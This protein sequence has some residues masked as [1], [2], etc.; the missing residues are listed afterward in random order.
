MNNKPNNINELEDKQE[1]LSTKLSTGKEV[2]PSESLATIEPQE[3]CLKNEQEKRKRGRPR[4]LILA[5]TQT[6]V[7]E[8]SKVGT[9]HEDIAV[10]LGFSEDT[11]TKYYRKE[12]DKGRI[13]ANAAVAGTLYEK[14]KQ[15]DTA[16]M[17]FWLKTRAGWSEKNTTELTGEGGA[18]INIKVV[19]GID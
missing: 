16:S 10:L 9:R 1:E 12:L 4:H 11:L 3:K 5:T 13:E 8:L 18:P 14:A 2:K 6:D 15:G 17:M 7:Y 19:T